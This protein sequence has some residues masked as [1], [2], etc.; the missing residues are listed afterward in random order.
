MDAGRVL[1]VVSEGGGTRQFGGAVR[2]LA[3]RIGT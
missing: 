1:R 2:K 3:L